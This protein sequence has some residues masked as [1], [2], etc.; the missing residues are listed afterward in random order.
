MAMACALLAERALQCDILGRYLQDAKSLNAHRLD[1]PSAD[2]NEPD[3]DDDP[4]A[5]RRLLRSIR[6]A[7]EPCPP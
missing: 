3:D 4:A 5:V 2:D 6:Y 1:W 7:R